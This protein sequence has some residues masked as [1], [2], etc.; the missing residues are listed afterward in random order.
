MRD[1]RGAADLAEAPADQADPV[2]EFG[3]GPH[4]RGVV[5]LRA[6]VQVDEVARRRR[7]LSDHAPDIRRE[8]CDGVAHP[9]RG[10]AKKNRGGLASKRDVEC[11]R[12]TRG[13]TADDD[14]I[15]V[16]GELVVRGERRRHPVL[17]TE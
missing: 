4:G 17:P 7:H 2:N 1:E 8:V 14:L 6:R 9:E 15:V 12:R 16:A 11:H 5:A 13:E 3:N 10:G